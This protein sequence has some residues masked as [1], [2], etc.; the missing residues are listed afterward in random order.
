MRPST[1]RPLLTTVL[2]TPVLVSLCLVSSCGGGV[3]P[4][5][6]T[7]VVLAVVPN[8][9]GIGGP[10]TL[11]ATVTVGGVAQAGQTVVFSLTPAGVANFTA[12]NAAVTDAAGNASVN[13]T[14][15]AAGTAT[16]TATAM[17]VTSV[18]QVLTVTPPAATERV[19]FYNST[20]IQF[21]VTS[22]TAG[23]A[24]S[25]ASLGGT[26]VIVGGE[27]GGPRV[28]VSNLTGTQAWVRHMGSGAETAFT[29]S[30]LSFGGTAIMARA[31]IHGA[32][33]KVFWLR[34]VGANR[35]VVSANF[36]GGGE[37]VLWGPVAA[38][39]RP[40]QIAVS[41]DGAN[42]LVVSEGGVV[43][44]IPSA[45]GSV[46]TISDFTNSG[47][48]AAIWLSNTEVAAAFTNC[49]GTGNP[50]ISR[51]FA[52]DDPA[53]LIFNAGGVGLRSAPQLLAR[54]AAG[55]LLFDELNVG[56]T[57][58]EI[59]RINAPVFGSRVG[60]VIRAQNDTMPLLLR[61]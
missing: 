16:A 14:G 37:S 52:N 2:L 36:N 31:A 61:W 23:G 18:G 11:T 56:L 44:R 33:G 3:T 40:N 45:G 55:N 21:Q 15:A 8:A 10:S 38:P 39:G 54:D 35:E 22:N 53:Q 29:P 4:P 7:A 58:R 5:A 12:G 17:G 50:G 46:N 28:L 26:R 13:V 34:N 30:A 60:I 41:P 57:Q 24:I 1:L 32:T 6:V 43:R 59:Q 9:V 51:L 20:D 42:V 47:A 49:M 25:N 19:L 48:T 27:V